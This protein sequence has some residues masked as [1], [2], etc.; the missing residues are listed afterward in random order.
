MTDPADRIIGLY[1]DKAEGWIADRGLALGGPGKSIDEVAALDRFASA[2]PSGASVLDV[3]CGSGWPWGAALLDRGFRVTGIDASRHLI[4]HARRTLPDGA[5]IVGDM[6]TFDLGRNFDG[7]LIWY[8]LFHLPPGD[9]EPA[10]G[11]ILGHASP[12]VVLMMTPFDAPGVVIGSWRGEPLYHASL[13]QPTYTALLKNFGL[14]PAPQ[15]ISTATPGTEAWIFS[16][17]RETRT[18]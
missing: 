14:L 7:I 3:G 1:D 9:Q 18:L 17:R 2:L 6:R 11:R 13:G 12:E 5:W 15:A 8:S 16:R 10:L 4:A